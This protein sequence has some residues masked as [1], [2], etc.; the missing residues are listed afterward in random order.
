MIENNRRSPVQATAREHFRSNV[1][2]RGRA[3]PDLCRSA[4]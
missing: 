2:R 1:E 4:K 3:V